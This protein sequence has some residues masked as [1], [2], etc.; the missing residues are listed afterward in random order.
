[1][2]LTERLDKHLQN[3]RESWYKGL[4]KEEPSFISLEELY[5]E[6]TTSSKYRKFK[7]S[8]NSFELTDKNA[9]WNTMFGSSRNEDERIIEW[10]TPKWAD[11]LR[12]GNYKVY[13]GFKDI[14]VP[15]EDLRSQL[16]LEVTT[17]GGKDFGT[18]SFT[19]YPSDKDSIQTVA[20]K[21]FELVLKYTKMAII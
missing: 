8:N 13:L 6:L 20:N 16:R 3:V 15:I 12:Y 7:I 18:D 4:Y 1:M 2:N 5:K 14:T 11:S 19:I 21:V 9:S 17:K 10:S